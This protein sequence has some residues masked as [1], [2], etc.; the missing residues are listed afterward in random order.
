MKEKREQRG[1]DKM[2]DEGQHVDTS[3]DRTLWFEVRR[4]VLCLVKQTR[5]IAL[6]PPSQR[7]RIVSPTSISSSFPYTTLTHSVLKAST[8]KHNKTQHTKTL[9]SI[10]STTTI[11][12]MSIAHIMNTNPTPY[13]AT[14]CWRAGR[15]PSSKKI[16]TPIP[17]I[18][19]R[20]GEV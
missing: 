19:S 11:T 17:T 20:R 1:N 4:L 12:T 3:Q 7:I 14:T 9:Q 10:L 8:V 16:A 13:L 15:E 6:L 18:H 2:M 5:R